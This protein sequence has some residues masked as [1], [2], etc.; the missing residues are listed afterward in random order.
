[1]FRLKVTIIILE[2]YSK[3]KVYLLGLMT[4]LKLIFST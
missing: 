1:M 3:V 4:N 2:N